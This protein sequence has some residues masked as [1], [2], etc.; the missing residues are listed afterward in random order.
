[1]GSAASSGGGQKVT[2]ATLLII[3]Q[4]KTVPISERQKLLADLALIMG[5]DTNGDGV[6]DEEELKAFVT[7]FQ[8]VGKDHVGQD[9][10]T[11]C[12]DCK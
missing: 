10:V 1:M 7:G 3:D 4:L 12:K 8:G 5:G 2:D 11:D 6:I 9:Q